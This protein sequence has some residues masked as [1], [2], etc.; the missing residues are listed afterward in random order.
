M[1]SQSVKEVMVLGL[2][3]LGENAVLPGSEAAM[4]LVNVGNTEL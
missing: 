1:L 4:S 2:K 3:L